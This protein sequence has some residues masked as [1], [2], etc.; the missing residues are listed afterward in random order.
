MSSSPERVGRA[1]RVIRGS[2]RTEPVVHGCAAGGLRGAP[3]KVVGEDALLRH[4]GD[5]AA[6]DPGA[7][8]A[9][10]AEAGR[11]SFEEGR[12]AGNAEAMASVE[13]R[14]AE[15]FAGLAAELGRAAAAAAGLRGAVLGEVLGD[16]A[17]LA[18]TLAEVLVG[19]ELV[20]RAAPARDAIER[21]LGVA[22]RGADLVVHVHPDCGLRDKEI[23]ALAASRDVRVV[24]DPSVDPDGCR[25]SVGA[26]EIDVQIPAAI[27][28][29]RQALDRLLPP[30][31][32]LPAH[33]GRTRPRTGSARGSAA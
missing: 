21:A 30:P 9:A 4:P 22:P 29:V 31:G 19:H 7:E 12:L 14:R 11:A 17:E 23:A 5:V 6:T 27:E 25:V 1:V 32:M 10:A 2:A 24:H 26:C 13:A 16:A 18:V 20:M 33:P 28:R 15:A 8:D 3:A